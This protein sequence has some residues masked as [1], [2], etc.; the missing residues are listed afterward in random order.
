MR[1]GGH[2]AHDELEQ[3]VC[4]AAAGPGFEGGRAGGRASVVAVRP[5]D[6]R[7][8][9][10]VREHEGEQG[11]L[12]DGDGAHD[13][14]RVLPHRVPEV[15]LRDDIGRDERVDR[16]LLQ[17]DDRDDDL[18]GEELAGGIEAAHV[19]L[20]GH[21]D[22]EDGVHGDGGGDEDEGADVA[23]VCVCSGG[24]GGGEHGA[25]QACERL[26]EHH[27]HDGDAEVPAH[28]A[29]G[30]GAAAKDGAMGTVAGQNEG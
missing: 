4:A 20:G 26:D 3:L 14:L 18:D 15:S 7:V 24:R 11:H 8:A 22:G 5:P 30:D 25:D 6:R 9:E 2:V 17:E 29:W 13:A 10:L 16:E 21:V 23:A 1:R 12:D 19:G 27:L 28:A